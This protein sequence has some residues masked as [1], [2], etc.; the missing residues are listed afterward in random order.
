MTLV[1]PVF[2]VTSL[3]DFA[4]AAGQH[5]SDV[6]GEV[7]LHQGRGAGGRSRHEAKRWTQ[8]QPGR[9]R[10]WWI[11]LGVGVARVRVPG[12]T[13]ASVKTW[14]LGT[15]YGRLCCH[16]ITSQNRQEHLADEG[17]RADLDGGSETN[18]A[19]IESS[20]YRHLR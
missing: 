11:A 7:G 19:T 14:L 15:T 6:E 10:R 4:H 18:V 20:P 9:A 13:R 17:D 2:Q 5:V 12:S 8:G 16:R 1:G 3:A